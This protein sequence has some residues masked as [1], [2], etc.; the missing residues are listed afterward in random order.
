[1]AR[2]LTPGK[3]GFDHIV[4]VAGAGTL[5]QVIKAISQDGV[6]SLIGFMGKG[7]T[8]DLM[9][10]LYGQFIV[11]GVGIG[12]RAQADEMVRA[13]EATDL[14]PVVDRVFDFKDVRDAYQHLEDQGFVGKVVIKYD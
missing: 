7:E 3:V 2:D 8:P 12:S 4:D 13:I 14:K 9:S 1:M 10:A 5:G 11:R 6:I